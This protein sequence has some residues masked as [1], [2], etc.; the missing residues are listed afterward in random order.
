MENPYNLVCY[1][2]RITKVNKYPVQD[3]ELIQGVDRAHQWFY[4]SSG[5]YAGGNGSYVKF[6]QYHGM[7]LDI[8]YALYDTDS[9]FVELGGRHWKIP[10]HITVDIYNEILARLGRKKISQ[11]AYADI[12]S[13]EGTKAAL[14]I[15]FF[16]D[17]LRIDGEYAAVQAELFLTSDAV[18]L[19]KTQQLCLRAAT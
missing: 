19:R 3:T 4:E 14:I 18:P 6:G 8:T 13:W 7:R 15:R 1:A 17:T 5:K 2:G 9:K 10:S 12:R 16:D 11:A